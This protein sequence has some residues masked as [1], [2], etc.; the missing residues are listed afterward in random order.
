MDA[1]VIQ[2]TGQ[3]QRTNFAEWK[4]NL[5]AQI[6]AANVT[7]ATD[8][9][10]FVAAEQVKE[11]KEA[12]KALKEAKQAAIDQAP[13]IH[14]LFVAIDEI[15]AQ[16]RQVRLSLERQVKH[17]K[18]HLK[19]E[20]IDRALAELHRLIAEQGPDL[21][22]I[23]LTPY[24]DAAPFEQAAKGKSTMKTL[25]AAVREVCDVTKAELR[26]RAA[27]VKANRALLD[28]LPRH[29]RVLFQDERALLGMTTEALQL[30]VEKRVALFKAETARQ[31]EETIRA[32]L[33]HLED[34]ALNEPSGPTA[35]ATTPTGAA[36]G[37]A[38]AAAEASSYQ[39]ILD[40]RCAQA[41]AVALAR[42][43]KQR[44]GQS[45]LVARVRLTRAEE[46]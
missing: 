39:L 25:Y 30:T 19:G 5:L 11:L 34:A 1:L 8:A 15:S 43:V 7:L 23:D 26:Q 44:Y 29:E 4:A 36:P 20:C 40:L 17:R 14:R 45:P 35:L 46:A 13:E 22:A 37:V 38:A 42:E 32:R 18:E 16:C 33:H 27:M 41:D 28:A 10:F 9:D 2:I 31:R 6:S 21:Q 3:L 24:L 12:E